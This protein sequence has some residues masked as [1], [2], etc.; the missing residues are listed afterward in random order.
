MEKESVDSSSTSDYF[1]TQKTPTKSPKSSEVKHTE[2]TLPE[3]WERG[4]TSEGQVYYI[5]HINK[6]TQW[7][8]PSQ[9]SP[10]YPQTP[11]YPKTPILQGQPIQ[12]QPIQGELIQG[13]TIQSQPIQAQSMQQVNPCQNGM[14]RL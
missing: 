12:G 10:K 14:D 2:D 11:K 6:K 3:G 13:Q 1:Q 7:E 9:K 8:H 4:V 5:D